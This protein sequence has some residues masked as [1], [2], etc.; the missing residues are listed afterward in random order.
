MK[1]N[2]IIDHFI[3]S[4][5]HTNSWLAEQRESEKTTTNGPVLSESE[6]Y[7]LIVSDVRNMLQLPSQK[8]T[9]GDIGF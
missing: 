2:K 9:G 1:D 5:R 4:S 6:D 3:P 7:L 8:E